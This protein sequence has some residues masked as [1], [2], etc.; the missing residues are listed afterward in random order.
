MASTNL[1]Q[2][3]YDAELDFID[4]MATRL[5]D[6]DYTRR[7]LLNQSFPEGSHQPAPPIQD[8]YWKY[9]AL[10]R[11]AVEGDWES[12]KKFFEK[13]QDA[14]TANINSNLENALHIA[15]QA[16]KKAIHVVKNLVEEMPIEALEHKNVYGQTVLSFA[17]IVG[18]MRA[19]VILVRKHS[20]L[21]YIRNKY[22]LLPVH[23]AAT[24]DHKDTFQYL[25]SVTQDQHGVVR[26]FADRSGVRLVI[27]VIFSGYYD[28]ALK[29]I[30]R[31][32]ELAKLQLPNGD[33][34]LSAIALK[35]SAFPSGS[36]L[37]FWESAI[38]SCVP[39]KLDKYAKERSRFD[40]EDPVPKHNLAQTFVRSFY[41][42]V[43]QRLQ[44]MLHKV[45]AFLVPHI[46]QIG[47]KKQVH[48]Q[49]TRLVKLL[50]QQ[51]AT[52]NDYKAYE[53]IVKGPLLSAAKLG[54]KEVV[55]DIL[56][57]FPDA[58]WFSDDESRFVFELA[59]LHRQEKVFNIIYQMDLCKH[60][61][62]HR[63][64]KEKNN[65]LHLAGRLAP[66]SRLNLIPGA[67]LQMQRELQWFKE[68]EKFVRPQNKLEKNSQG[69]IPAMLF[70]TEHKDLVREGEKWMKDTANSCTIVASLI[71]TI[72][73]A[74]AI[75]SPG[76]NS[77][78]SGLPIFSKKIAFIIFAIS[79]A[80]SLFT[81]STSLLMFLSIL[82]SRYEESD[83]L[84][85]LP[86]R[87]II[88]LVTL[89][90]SITTMMVAFTA[91]LYLGAS[92]YKECILISSVAVAS[93]PIYIFTSLQFPLLLDLIYSTY[94]TIFGKKNDSSIFLQSPTGK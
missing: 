10:H 9:I 66:P 73:F 89:F 90:L 20:R 42:P 24:Y 75:T 23:L 44:A 49:A 52:L 51:I 46:K 85:V 65:I 29:L 47:E 16:G 27:Q 82:T 19:V 61:L 76:G 18:N 21:L 67:A 43:S 14:V 1:L 13:N 6:R 5:V 28:E 79:N 50:C 68:V 37:S 35:L 83:F 69:K 59:I 8:E 26:P 93:V 60:L 62:S 31:Y 74:A 25:L 54:V 84:Y 32:P 57:S 53:S 3:H 2:P 22:M 55:E 15:V 58:V 41:I 78:D 91:T 92:K 33:S 87:L 39:L 4:F 40:I 86:K 81:S 38:Y 11:A 71:A 70:T 88:G 45:L 12:A 56:D 30:D 34:V 80:L 48:H 64:D 63:F 17:A 7:I 36:H 94:G 72:A 77:S